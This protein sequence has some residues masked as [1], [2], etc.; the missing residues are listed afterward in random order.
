MRLPRPAEE[1]AD[2]TICENVSSPRSSPHTELATND[3]TAIELSAGAA[4]MEISRLITTFAP[5]AF[6]GGTEKIE[7]IVHQS[8][9]TAQQVRA[10]IHEQ[11]R[12]VRTVDTIAM[13]VRKMT[14]GL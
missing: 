8:E 14:L 3:P 2:S 11:R 12:M 1:G 6:E 13:L 7:L 9:A 10:L 4:G 5:S